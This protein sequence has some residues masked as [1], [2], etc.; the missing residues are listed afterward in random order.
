MNRTGSAALFLVVLGL[1]ALLLG[2]SFAGSSGSGSSSYPLTPLMIDDFEDGDR[3]NRLNF[4]MRSGTGDDIEITSETPKKGSYALRLVSDL[5]AGSTGWTSVSVHTG[6]QGTAT[7]A[8]ASA[9]GRL[10]FNLGLGG[11]VDA[12]AY[13]EIELHVLG[14]T[15]NSIRYDLLSDFATDFDEYSIALSDFTVS[16]G[17][18]EAVKGA[19]HQVQ[20]LV[21]VW[22]A[23]GDK[24]GF[25]LVVT[26]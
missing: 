21:F 8:D 15:G 9:Y 6:P 18:L 2:C 5:T 19:V 23:Q 17:S 22:G 10:C 1:V 12:G 20:F 16:Q 24:L 3:D 7:P 11:M 25:H 26:I 4:W 13:P 14:D